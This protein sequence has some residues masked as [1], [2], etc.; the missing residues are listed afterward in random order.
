MKI[1]NEA[2]RAMFEETID[3]CHRTIWLITPR[4]EN[5]DLKNPVDRCVGI[6][7]MVTATDYDEPE[8]FTSCC[9]D[10]MMMFEFI[11]AQK[12]S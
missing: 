8:I 6:A 7:K 3:R 2:E 9:E 11:A 10:E 5:Y 1:R 4:G 12:A